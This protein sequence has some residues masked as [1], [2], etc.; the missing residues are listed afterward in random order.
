MLAILAEKETADTED[1]KHNEHISDRKRAADRSSTQPW[2]RGGRRQEW[3]GAGAEIVQRGGEMSCVVVVHF[4]FLD[5]RWQSLASRRYRPRRLSSV[6][7]G[8]GQRAK[9]AD[10]P[11]HAHRAIRPVGT[12]II[13]R[14]RSQL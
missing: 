8:S 4:S 1:G 9:A 10:Q 2:T 11:P 3:V 6:A 7:L 14:A 13:Q 12:L 5:R